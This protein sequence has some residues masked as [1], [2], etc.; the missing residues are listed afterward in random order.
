MEE[1]AMA[2]TEILPEDAGQPEETPAAQD[3]AMEEAAPMVYVGPPI[4]GTILHSTFTV[5]SDG[6][7][8]EYREHPALRYL[9]VPPGQ[10]DRA[11]AEIGRK[12]TPR[13]AFY[14]RAAKEFGRK[15]GK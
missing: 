4:K 1:T 6:I 11:R 10:L 3:G 13:N 2:A 7:P 14:M 12:G 9:F 5:F 15:G 8:G